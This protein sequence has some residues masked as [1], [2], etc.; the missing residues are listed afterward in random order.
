MLPT[1]DNV[2]TANVEIEVDPSHR[3]GGA[4]RALVA[5]AEAV[6]RSEG[7]TTVSGGYEERIGA[8][9]PGQEFSEQLGYEPAL[10]ELRRDLGLPVDTGR[11]DDLEA[12]CH[13]FAAGYR[14][15]AWQGKCPDELV[16]G[17]LELERDM[18]ADAP[19]GDLDHEV[20]TW[21]EPR[22]RAA[23]TTVEKMGHI[24]FSAG[25]VA[26]RTGQL[27]AVTT[28]GVLREVPTIGRQFATVV[29]HAD[30]GHRL[31]M[32]VKIANI[33]ALMER[34]P[35][36]SKVMTFNGETNSH[37]SSVNEELGYK[38]TARVVICQKHLE[39]HQ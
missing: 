32:L 24:A 20:Q 13:P 17:R 23:E 9:A 31:G 4:G 28:I 19:H 16:E 1:R 34:T 12:A 10:V 26:E 37:M 6:A 11:L 30:R 36:T 2:W 7:R 14:I 5:H 27:V 33:R 39:A 25:A 18:S 15:V 38:V 3:R 35:V 8:A 22:L 29:S 21:D